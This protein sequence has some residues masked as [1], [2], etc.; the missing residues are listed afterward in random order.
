LPEGKSKLEK[1]RIK[2]IVFS[3]LE[4][5]GGEAGLDFS[6]AGLALVQDKCERLSE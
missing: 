1:S 3:I 5:F 4:S 2:R 6:S